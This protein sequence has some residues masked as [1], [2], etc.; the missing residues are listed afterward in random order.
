MSSSQYGGQASPTETNTA[1][2]SAARPFY[3]FDWDEISR[4][5]GATA[6]TLQNGE[7]EET[8]CALVTV[9]QD[10]RPETKKRSYT[11]NDGVVG[12]R[13]SKFFCTWLYVTTDSGEQLGAI[14][15]LTE[16][17]DTV[18]DFVESAVTQSKAWYEPICKA[19]GW[20]TVEG[21]LREMK[22]EQM[23]GSIRDTL[24]AIG[25]RFSEQ[26]PES[27]EAGYYVKNAGQLSEDLQ[28][29]NISDDHQC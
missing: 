19:K 1:C 12:E 17:K 6:V 28:Q 5:L 9:A 22:A 24:W 4:Q 16:E 20:M 21:L 18:M 8:L 27:F 23:V 7:D 14:K 11:N 26:G 15:T 3:R 10:S 29:L 25:T 2:L 13:D